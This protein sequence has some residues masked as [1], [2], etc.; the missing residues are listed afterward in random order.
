MSFRSLFWDR[1]HLRDAT[2]RELREYLERVRG[3]CVRY[4]P[5]LRRFVEAGKLKDALA[6]FPLEEIRRA[7]GTF[8][9]WKTPELRLRAWERAVGWLEKERR[10]APRE[11]GE[12]WAS[13]RQRELFLQL[14]REPRVRERFYLTGG[15]CLAV[16]YLGHRRSEDLS[17][18]AAREADFRE[19]AR[20]FR[21]LTGGTAEVESEH[22][23]RYSAGGVRVDFVWDALSLPEEFASLEVES[24][25]TVKLDTP[26]NIAVNK[27]CAVVSRG[28]PK[29]VVDLAFLLKVGAVGPP[30]LARL[31]AGAAER[32]AALDDPLYVSAL[33]EELA[34]RADRALEEVRS[35]LVREV[36]AAEMRE[37]LLRLSSAA[38]ALHHISLPPP[39]PGTP[40]GDLHL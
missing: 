8:R 2:H 13:P 35:L 23:C 3:D 20:L 17:L 9:F 4:D 39:E 37:A 18:F 29:D 38:S 5:V 21:A 27:L 22:Y 16:F 24:G 28:E 36:A 6:V 26:F 1:P 7:L 10:F 15:T 11:H 19:N 40:G 32:E 30:S 34:E 33:L 31:F 25:L 14:F 12:C